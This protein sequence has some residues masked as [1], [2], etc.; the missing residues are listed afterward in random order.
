MS[1]IQRIPEE[2]QQ[3]QAWRNG[4]GWTRELVRI[5]SPAHFTWRAS[6]ASIDRPGPF[7]EF[8]GCRRHLSLLHGEALCLQ[9]PDGRELEIAPRLKPF[10]FAGSPAPVCCSVD[11]PVEVFN[12]IVR[13]QERRARLLPRPLVGSM[14]L[15]DEPGVEWFIHL[16]SGEAELRRGET[17]LH[18]GSNQSL[19]FC[20]DGSGSRAV[21]DGG[22]EVVLAR[23]E[24]V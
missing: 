19:L 23:L 15:F 17:R 21:L 20:C 7:S 16:L 14:L 8:P 18:L 10:D 13:E 6:I 9:W 4:G 3:R 24:K 12:L 5:G 1:T 2:L 22:G 11:G